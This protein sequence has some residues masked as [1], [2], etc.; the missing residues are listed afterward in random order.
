M[1][2][3]HSH[4]P[5][6]WG[7]YG[8]RATILGSLLTLTLAACGSGGHTAST[9]AAGTTYP[10]TVAYSLLATDPLMTQ[11]LVTFT[12]NTGASENDS[13]TTSIWNQ[14]VTFDRPVP[15]L[16]LSGTAMSPS[17]LGDVECIIQLDGKTVIQRTGR[18]VVSCSFNMPTR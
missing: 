18:G 17:G 8:A 11:L 6:R 3:S 1:K 10:H 2:G 9:S 13:T 15:S 14:S 7:S 16:V 5:A 12:N 4:L